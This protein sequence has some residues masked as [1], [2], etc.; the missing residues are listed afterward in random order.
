LV[1]DALSEQGEWEEAMAISGHAVAVSEVTGNLWLLPE[2]YRISGNIFL[3]KSS[4]DVENAQKS[5]R[6][7]VSFSQHHKMPFFEQRALESLEMIK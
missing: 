1:A 5:F 7:A 2:V 4:P 6:M 3:R